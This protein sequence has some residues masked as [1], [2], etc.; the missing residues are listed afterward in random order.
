MARQYLYSCSVMA[1]FARRSS[2][3]VFCISDPSQ[4]FIDQ[5]M[6]GDSQFP[7]PL[8]GAAQDF[9]SVVRGGGIHHLLH[10]GPTVAKCT[11]AMG[12]VL[13]PEDAVGTHQVE[14]GEPEFVEHE[15]RVEIVMPVIFDVFPRLPDAYVSMAC[16]DE[17]HVL[18]QRCAPIDTALGED[19]L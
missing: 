12:V 17:S 4:S 18:Q 16:I 3:C 8:G 11:F 9:A 5:P 15:R 10:G 14:H 19:D 13:R 6:I 7:Q 1:C 2:S